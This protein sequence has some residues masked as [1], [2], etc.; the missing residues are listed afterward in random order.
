M[1]Y[2]C[3]IQY[4]DPIPTLRCAAIK[5]NRLTRFVRC[6]IRYRLQSASESD[7]KH[8]FFILFF[9]SVGNRNVI[10]YRPSNTCWWSIFMC[11]HQTV[12]VKLN[13]DA[14]KIGY[15]LRE[16]SSRR[17]ANNYCPCYTV[18]YTIWSVTQVVRLFFSFFRAFGYGFK[19]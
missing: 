7:N 1:N 6:D 4:I 3:H 18:N 12:F 9:D 17:Y 2:R 15:L 13:F 16:Q 8:R 5:R 10:I 19:L 11:T 14:D